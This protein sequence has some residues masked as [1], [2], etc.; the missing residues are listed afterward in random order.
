MK[1]K[2]LTHKQLE[3][4]ERLAYLHKKLWS[5]NKDGGLTDNEDR[6]YNRLV[7]RL[8]SILPF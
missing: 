2:K 3:N 5:I 6:E 8:K 7:R 1:T 4:I